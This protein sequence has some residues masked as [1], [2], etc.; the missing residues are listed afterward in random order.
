MTV[1]AAFCVVAKAFLTSF[2]DKGKE[3][4]EGPRLQSFRL[5]G[6]EI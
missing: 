5:A 4:I 1:P 6:C 2:L 3:S